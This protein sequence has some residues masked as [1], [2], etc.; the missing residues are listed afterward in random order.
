MFIFRKTYQPFNDALNRR[1]R[2]L[3][4]TSEW[5]Q[6][7]NAVLQVKNAVKSESTAQNLQHKIQHKLPH[8]IQH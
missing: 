7:A 4:F 2:T 8:K 3:R 1:I 5:Q 6:N